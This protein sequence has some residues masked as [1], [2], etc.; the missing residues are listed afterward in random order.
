MMKMRNKRKALHKKYGD[1]NKAFKNFTKLY[2]ASIQERVA[3]IVQYMRDNP[4][5]YSAW[6][7]LEDA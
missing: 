5:N 4:I 3:K 1:V 6:E 2:E 7:S